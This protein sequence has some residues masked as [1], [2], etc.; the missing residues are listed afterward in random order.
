M[1]ETIAI[2]AAD[3]HLDHLTW[4]KRP[5]IRGDSFYAF[6]QLV[7]RAIR[8]KVPLIV[9][10]DVVEGLR[11]GAPNSETVDFLSGQVRK[12]RDAGV[13]FYYINGQH[14]RAEPA[15]PEAC[16]AGPPQRGAVNISGVPTWF[17]SWQPAEVINEYVREIP[18]GTRLLVIHQVCK[19]LMGGHFE[20]S[21]ADVPYG[22]LIISGDLHQYKEVE[23]KTIHK[24]CLSALSVGATSMRKINEPMEYFCIRLKRDLTWDKVMLYSRPMLALTLND[25]RA[26]EQAAEELPTVLRDVTNKACEFQYPP[27]LVKPILVVQDN[28]ELDGIHARLADMAGDSAHL[29]YQRVNFNLADS[30]SVI[31]SREGVDQTFAEIVHKESQDSGVAEFIIQ[32]M[33][34][35]SPKNYVRKYVEDSA[36]PKQQAKD[37]P[38]KEPVIAPA[39]TKI[40]KPIGGPRSAASRSRRPRQI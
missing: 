30:N 23:V 22:E 9:A 36:D 10:G 33:K 26:V 15:W 12:L 25:S 2:V 40:E 21:L 7:D 6:C 20:L 1:S 37:V 17:M 31:K 29:F 35:T 28:S 8:E 39:R 27:E 14:D 4:R 32:A 13:P 38:K 18:K 5:E 24:K 34:D 11:P 16:G 3:T 19:E